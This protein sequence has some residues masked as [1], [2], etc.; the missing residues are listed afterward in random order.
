MHRIAQIDRVLAAAGPA[1]PAPPAAAG[2][3]TALRGAAGLLPAWAAAALGGPAGPDA[4]VAPARFKPAA[5]SRPSTAAAA[6][7]AV[8]VA[9]HAAWMRLGLPRRAVDALMRCAVW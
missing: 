1:H 2:W 4:W 3:A 8:A 5:G 7:P 6:H 9:A